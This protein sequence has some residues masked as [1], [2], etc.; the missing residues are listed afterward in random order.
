MMVVPWT[1]L[2]A[3][4]P[5]S[6]TELL[7]DEA[8]RQRLREE[9]TR[10]AKD[11]AKLLLLW[12]FRAAQ[13]FAGISFLFV[14][15][16]MLYALLY[17]LV[18]PSRFHEQEIFF[19]Y[20]KHHAAIVQGYP[21][22]P[23]ASLD[24]RDS[25]HQWDALVPKLEQSTQPVLVPGVKYDV[26]VELTVPESRINTEVGVFM[27]STWLY[28]NPE[29]GLAASARPVTLHDMPAPVRWLKLGFWLLPYTLGFT[30]PAQTLRVTAINGYQER[31][32]YPL[33]RVDIELNTPK[34]QVYSAKLT[35]IAQLTGLRYLMYYWAVPT[36][37]L[38]I[39][40]IVFV[41]A[42]VLVILY[43]VYALPQLDEEAAA[44]A[45][46]LEAAA[47][48]AR[49]KAKKLFEAMQGSE[50]AKQ[51]KSETLIGEVSFTSTSME[52]SSEVFTEASEETEDIK[53][54]KMDVKK[55]PA[56]NAT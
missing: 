25:V 23:R 45:A 40:N 37:I 39:L 48:D 18:I 21:D 44:D 17:Y 2:L 42:L 47:A 38:F 1:L 4:L 27:V 9:L 46:V 6:A 50:T 22:L 19:H 15:A 13:V 36:A 11:Y 52:E 31:T 12:S 55:E 5:T 30:E 7:K 32:D 35:V 24:L 28:A 51:V 34:L 43:A 8:E 10:V 56:V 49:D 20:G 54:E 29:K 26:I 53:E 14:T 3:L 16:S 41:E 33:T